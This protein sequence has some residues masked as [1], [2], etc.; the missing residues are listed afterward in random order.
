MNQLKLE[1]LKIWNYYKLDSYYNYF[2]QHIAI[3]E[4]IAVITKN[5]K[6]FVK[7]TQTYYLVVV[8]ISFS[9]NNFTNLYNLTMLEVDCTLI[10]VDN[11]KFLELVDK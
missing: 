1:E 3:I 9:C 7:I 8:I 2:K 5:Y 4:V 6:N 11:Y 10:L